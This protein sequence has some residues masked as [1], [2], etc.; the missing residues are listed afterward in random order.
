MT[1]SGRVLDEPGGKGV[2]DIQLTLQA[3]LSYF[4]FARTASNGSYSMAVDAAADKRP[5]NLLI[6]AGSRRG[7]VDPG[8][9][10]NVAGQDLA[11]KDLYLRL[12]QSISGTV[13]NTS[14]PA[15]R[16]RPSPDRSG[17]EQL[18]LPRKTRG[19][20]QHLHSA[21][22]GRR[23]PIPDLLAA[24]HG[25][26]AQAG[27]TGWPNPSDAGAT[28]EAKTVTLAAGQ[29]VENVDL[30]LRAGPPFSGIVLL[31][32]GRPAK[33]ASVFLRIPELRSRAS[34]DD[35]PPLLKPMLPRS[36]WILASSR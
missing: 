29:V 1:I 14:E 9:R 10:L 4:V 30:Q 17:A 5:M 36:A 18:L 13:R 32:D 15:S 34:W 28:S 31:P 25:F 27:G 24:G 16:G 35:P 6:W 22:H 7:A 8:L 2:G 12:P 21:G 3:G 33:D 11:A 20:Q 19:W 26:R 23:R